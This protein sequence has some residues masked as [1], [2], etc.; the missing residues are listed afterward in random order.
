MVSRLFLLAVAIVCGLSQSQAPSSPPEAPTGYH[1]LVDAYRVSGPAEVRLLLEMP[2]ERI[3]AEVARAIAD[4]SGWQWSDLR[5]AAM[6]HT[7]AAFSR[8]RNDNTGAADAHL[9]LAQRLLTRVTSLSPPQE[10]FEWRWHLAVAGMLE[11][12]RVRGL[13]KRLNDY[14]SARWA[15]QRGR[16]MY[17]RGLQFEAR[18]NAEGRVLRP[19]DSVLMIPP[20][21]LQSHWFVLAAS[22]FTAALKEDPT[23]GAAA[24]HLGR[25]RTIQGHRGDAIALLQQSL[26][27]VD[28]A[29]VYMSALLLG[30]LEEREERFDAAEKFYRQALSAF[31]YGQSAPLALAQ[32][33]SRTGR[34]GA[35]R[36]TLLQ[37]LTTPPRAIE[38]SWAYGAAPEVENGTRVG[39]LRAETW[40]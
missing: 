21:R 18:G 16:E 9:V 11:E 27:H 17:V 15:T 28:P 19:G 40:K 12:L 30:S 22:A 39:L 20:D 32:L 34:D 25:I 38:P 14:A 37:R 1:A 26:G 10:D 3:S 7:E 4:N 31:P 33:L 23:L 6:L 13:P 8:V 29:V 24:L 36:S 5:A 35:A 2:R